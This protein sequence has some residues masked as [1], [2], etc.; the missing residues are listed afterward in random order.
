LAE[1]LLGTR[2]GSDVERE[3]H[4]MTRKKSQTTAQ[5]PRGNASAPNKAAAA[6]KANAAKKTTSAAKPAP[7]RKANTKA[8]LI[9][10]AG[11]VLL[12][13]VFAALSNVK[14]N[15]GGG[16]PPEEQKYIG[17]FL[18]AGYQEPKLAEVVVYPTATQMTT[19][20]ATD[21]GKQLSVPVKDIVGDKIVYWEYKKPGSAPI[22][23]LAYLKVSGKLFVGVS[24][25][26]PC[27]GKG[28]RI[29]PDLTLTCE[30]CGTK[31]NL[32]TGVGISGACKLYPTDEM[33]SKVVGGNVVIDKSV[34]DGWTPQPKDR[35]IGA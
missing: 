7:P 30:T 16:A 28:Q 18:P 23:M 9:A 31:R 27:E 1:Q 3:V 33:P 10:G 35:K 21:S 32:E 22:P 19:V 24:F 15:A 5:S 11:I 8:V 20:K 17:R 13:A 25:C 4:G 26:P 6:A 12:I 2:P 34:I 14:P 29:E